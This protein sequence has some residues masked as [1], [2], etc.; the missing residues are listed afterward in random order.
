MAAL[1]GNTDGSGGLAL[2]YMSPELKV[3]P[4]RRLAPGTSG[5]RCPADCDQRNERPDGAPGKHALGG[6]MRSAPHPRLQGD[7]EVE[8]YAMQANEAS[9]SHFGQTLKELYPTDAG[10]NAH[11]DAVCV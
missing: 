6:L 3:R 8:L 2:H 7:R 4:A 1:Q 11:N 5:A 10:V 9:K